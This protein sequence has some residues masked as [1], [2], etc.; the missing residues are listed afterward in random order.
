MDSMMEKTA[1]A[2]L[3]GLG[4][5]MLVA[6]LLSRMKVAAAPEVPAQ[7]EVPTLP[8]GEPQFQYQYTKKCLHVSY[9]PPGCTEWLIIGPKLSTTYISN[10]GFGKAEITIENKGDA[11]GLCKAECYIRSRICRSGEGCEAWKDEWTC[12]SL[13]RPSHGA[14]EDLGYSEDEFS[15]FQ[16]PEITEQIIP[17]GGK[18]TFTGYFWLSH[19][20]T[21]EIEAK[22]IGSAG[23]SG[24]GTVVWEWA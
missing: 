4:F 20:I 23:E 24:G 6:I 10:L 2:M 9:Y 15:Q 14:L 21:R 7:P 1:K 16:A 17:A 18:V 13:Y 11:P 5:L 22:F 12:S 8:S 3:A 19:N